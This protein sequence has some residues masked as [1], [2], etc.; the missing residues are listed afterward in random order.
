MPLSRSRSSRARSVRRGI[1][2]MRALGGTIA[3]EIAATVAVEIGVATGAETADLIAA[4]IV[5]RAPRANL[6]PPAL[7]RIDPMTGLAA[8]AASEFPPRT[9]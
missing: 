5:L 1:V 7:T 9:V 4:P 8:S 3:V 6:C 2:L